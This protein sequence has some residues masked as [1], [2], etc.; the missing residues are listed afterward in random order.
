MGK[1]KGDSIEV[2]IQHVVT[3]GPNDKAGWILARTQTGLDIPVELSEMSLSPLGYG[4]ERIEGQTLDLTIKDF[5][6]MNRPQLTNLN[7][8]IKDLSDLRKQASIGSSNEEG[9]VNRKGLD[10]KGY[11]EEINEDKDRV[12]V[13]VPR[14]FGVVHHF[15]INKE[16]VPTK[17]LS[18]L[19]IGEGVIVRL[20]SRDGKDEIPAD[21]LTEEELDKIPKDWSYDPTIAKVL[22]PYCLEDEDFSTW[23]ARTEI[24]DLL[25]RHSWRYCFSAR[26]V[27]TELYKYAYKVLKVN[28]RITGEVIEITKHQDGSSSGVNLQIE[29]ETPQGTFPVLGFLPLAEL[30]WHRITSPLDVINIQ[31]SVT[32]RI[33]EV[34]ADASPPKLILSRKKAFI[35]QA[36]IPYSKVGVLIGR[37][38]SRIKAIIGSNDV[39]IDTRA[40]PGNIIVQ[41]T[42]QS[43]RDSVCDSISS[44]VQGVGKWTKR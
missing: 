27:T 3:Q 43:V 16:Y 41:A 29:V 7:K 11:V 37:R 14:A 18:N 24:I 5:D 40:V 1:R 42:F 32:V 2:K 31:E 10:L 6:E 30:S 35:A 20:L 38:G 34:D 19:R 28:T 36:S 12:V 4:L 33:L 25:K 26:V 39:S 8:V 21:F 17:Q 13:V 23:P 22:V 15:E 9:D 44:Q